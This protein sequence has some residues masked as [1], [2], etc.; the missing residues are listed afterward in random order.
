M[1]WLKKEIIRHDKK[2]MKSSFAVALVI[3]CAL[4]AGCDLLTNKKTT[5]DSPTTPTSPTTASIDAF[6]G[7]WQSVAVSTPPTGCGNLKY[8]VTPT[9][10]SSANVTFSA[11]CASNI[12]V[13]GSGSGTLSGSVINWSANGLVSQ[14]GVNCP[15]TFANSKATQDTSGQIVVT[16]SGTVCGIPVSGTETVKK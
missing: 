15:F 3:T 14:G 10:A 4:S 12:A 5:S 7:T 2:I 13:T 16:Y 1:A 8:T 6:A 9:T 11:T